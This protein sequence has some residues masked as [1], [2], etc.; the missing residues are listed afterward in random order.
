[1][2]GLKKRLY[3][4]GFNQV[5]RLNFEE[6]RALSVCLWASDLLVSGKIDT[7]RGMS[8]SRQR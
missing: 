4:K 8:A 1:M 6:G 7:H 2:R 5:L 3:F